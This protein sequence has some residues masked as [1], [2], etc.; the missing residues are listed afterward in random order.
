M[1]QHLKV[2]GAGLIVWASKGG[3]SC[4]IAASV[5]GSSLTQRGS[6]RCLGS[7]VYCSVSH[8]RALSVKCDKHQYFMD[9][10]LQK[11]QDVEEINCRIW[12]FICS[13]LS[14][15]H[16]SQIVICYK[17]H[18]SLND[19]LQLIFDTVRIVRWRFAG[20]LESAKDI[21]LDIAPHWLIDYF[22]SRLF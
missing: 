15:T 6:R 14:H 9:D 7:D 3:L 20:I 4:K 1:S 12:S 5:I 16:S 2:W 8:C 10:E 18:S 13:H 22:L 19:Y 21:L 17:V 11:Y